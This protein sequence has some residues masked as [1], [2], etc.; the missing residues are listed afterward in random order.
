MWKAVASF[1]KKWVIVH[2]TTNLTV[3]GLFGYSSVNSIVNLKVPSSKGVSWGPKMT[4]F[5]SIMLLSLGAPDTP[6]NT[7][8]GVASH[9]NLKYT[10]C[11]PAG[12]SCCN[13]LKS[14]ISL[15]LAGVDISTVVYF[16]QAKILLKFT[17]NL[18]RIKYF[19]LTSLHCKFINDSRATLNTESLRTITVGRDPFVSQ[20]LYVWEQRWTSCPRQSWCPAGSDW[21]PP[22]C[23]SPA[24]LWDFRTVDLW[25]KGSNDQ[26]NTIFEY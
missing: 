11:L 9:W 23:W 6:C 13:L 17:L 1:D 26:R 22:G 18:Q 7:N 10:N 5:H 14:L 20:Q 15:R 21:R 8:K 3:G 24:I 19:N 25:N 4:A 16:N 12:G 2:E